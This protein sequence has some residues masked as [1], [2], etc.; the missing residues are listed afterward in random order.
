MQHSEGERAPRYYSSLTTSRRFDHPKT[1]HAVMLLPLN[2]H[3]SPQNLNDYPGDI[4]RILLT[5]L[6]SPYNPQ[7]KSRRG[8]EHVPLTGYVGMLATTYPPELM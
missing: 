5:R 8:R 6:L 2:L 3:E 7:I 1:E 4:P